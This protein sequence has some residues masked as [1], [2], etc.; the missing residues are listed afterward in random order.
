M[1]HRD[2]FYDAEYDE[3]SGKW[4]WKL[5]PKIGHGQREFGPPEFNSR[6]AALATAK[7]WSGATTRTRARTK[8][9]GS[10]RA[11][12]LVAQDSHGDG[13]ERRLDQDGAD[14]QDQDFAF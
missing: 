8:N 4:F 14:R 12:R 6:E 5:Y 3:T 11:A 2:V 9:P 1:K 7:P 13:E 10:P